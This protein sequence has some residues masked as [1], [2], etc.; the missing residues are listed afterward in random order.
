MTRAM[1]NAKRSKLL[2]KLPACSVEGSA[3][4]LSKGFEACY[5]AQARLAIPARYVCDGCRDV[6]GDIDDEGL[7]E[8]CSPEDEDE[9]TV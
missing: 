6:S 1:M 5:A 9:E 2:P 3:G 7:C 4:N 8:N